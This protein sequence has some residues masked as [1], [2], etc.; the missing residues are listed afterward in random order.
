MIGV[1]PLYSIGYEKA[2]LGDLIATLRAAGVSV[3]LDVRDRP[4]SRRPGFSKRQLA[5]AVEEAGLRY[6][7]LAAL[8]TP[9]E[10]RLANRRRDWPRFWAIVGD[11]LARPE[12]E[13]DL[14]RAAAI[15][16]A[17][18]SCLLCYEADWRCCHRARIA[19]ILVS[20]HGFALRH[21][22]VRAGDPS[23]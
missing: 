7:H 23:P 9:P 6:F 18:P 5:A 8:G 11:R 10:G 20:R 4:I 13:L 15:A 3:L 19:D 2:T 14:E 17:A 21:L 16:E 12:A 1:T 22:A